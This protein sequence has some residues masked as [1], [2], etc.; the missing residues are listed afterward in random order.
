MKIFLSI[1]L[2]CAGKQYEKGDG[3][4][5]GLLLESRQKAEADFKTLL[6][7]IRDEGWLTKDI[8]L[9]PKEKCSFNILKH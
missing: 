2:E 8:L 3:G 7:A 9:G 5:R 1:I 4:W 6:D